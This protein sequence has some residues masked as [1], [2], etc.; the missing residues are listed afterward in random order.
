MI[1]IMIL[2]IFS[3]VQVAPSACLRSKQRLRGNL[4][5][6]VPLPFLLCLQVHTHHHDDEDDDD[7]D[8]VLPMLYLH[9]DHYHD[10][11]LIMVIVV[12]TLSFKV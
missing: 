6:L 3:E 4:H 2:M 5:G 11:E 12:A 7:N 10:D 8:L 9:V 1:R